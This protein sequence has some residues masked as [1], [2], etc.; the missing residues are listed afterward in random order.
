MMQAAQGSI[1]RLEL[2][3]S[4]DFAYR[5]DT[6][7]YEEGQSMERL[8]VETARRI[9]EKYK[10]AF[11]QLAPIQRKF[12]THYRCHQCRL[13]PLNF[14]DVSHF[15]RVRCRQCGQ[16]VAFRNCGKYGKLR[17]EIAYEIWREMNGTD[18][19]SA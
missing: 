2:S 7:P 6:I 10:I 18:T 14:V 11:E 17:K 8:L 13:L 9:C 5:A 16:L 15:K 12:I 3:A 19:S 4:E 1:K